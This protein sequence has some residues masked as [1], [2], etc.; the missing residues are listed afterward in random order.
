MKISKV[1]ENSRPGD[2]YYLL[3]YNKPDSFVTSM[4]KVPGGLWR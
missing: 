2:S 3:C 1:L 4:L